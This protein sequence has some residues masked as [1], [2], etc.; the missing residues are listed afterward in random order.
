MLIAALSQRSKSLSRDKRNAVMEHVAHRLAEHGEAGE[1]FTVAFARLL[2]GSNATLIVA[3]R[4]A[5][6][7]KRMPRTEQKSN[8]STAEEF[9]AGMVNSFGQIFND[10]ECVNLIRIL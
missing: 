2:G 10:D 6:I 8:V 9:A 5:R 3:R 4:L 1:Q 7:T